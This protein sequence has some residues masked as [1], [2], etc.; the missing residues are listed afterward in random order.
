LLESEA[1]YHSFASWIVSQKRKRRPKGLFVVGVNGTVGQGKSYFSREVVRHLNRLLA[2]E[3]GQALTQSLDDYYLPKVERYR[4]EFLARGYN[5]EEVPNRGPAGTHDVAR[6]WGD[7]LKLEQS[8]KPSSPA[9]TGGGPIDLPVFDKQTDDHSVEPYRVIGKVGVFILDGW[10]LGCRTTVNPAQCDPGLKRSVAEALQNYR[11]IFQRLDALWAFE[12]PK[13]LD[14]IVAQRIE[15]QET[16][17]RE[18]GET[19]MSREEIARF[20][21]YFYVDAWQKGVTSPAADP[22]VVSFRAITDVRH[23]FLEITPFL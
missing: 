21:R 10:F 3:E 19:G 14:E 7:I 23:Q 11:P 13:S 16:L 17:N 4:P 9:V 20:V 8:Q 2:P 12:P 18:T 6:L 22:R 15:Q 1:V 5:P